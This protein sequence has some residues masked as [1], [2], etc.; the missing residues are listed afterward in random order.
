LAVLAGG[1]ANNIAG[2]S[3]IP[4]SQSNGS[5]EIASNRDGVEVIEIEGIYPLTV[6]Q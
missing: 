4:Q 3:T 2:P 1:E 6:A 5:R